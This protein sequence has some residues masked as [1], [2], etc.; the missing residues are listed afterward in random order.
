[1]RPLEIIVKSSAEE[2]HALAYPQKEMLLPV[3]FGEYATIHLKN[4][5]KRRK[6]FCS[7][8][9]YTLFGSEKFLPETK[10][11]TVERSTILLQSQE[12][13]CIENFTIFVGDRHLPYYPLIIVEDENSFGILLGQK[14]YDVI[15]IYTCEE[16]YSSFT[17]SLE[18]PEFEPFFNL[19]KTIK[20]V[21]KNIGL[22]KEELAKI[23]G[24]QI[25]VAL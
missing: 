9:E 12:E 5:F 18:E 14:C 4:G 16:T 17:S 23:R 21:K 22:Q 13:V 11:V 20:I 10:S 2:F 1:M 6:I 3:S 7:V 25:P 8:G 15:R 24:A 19:Y